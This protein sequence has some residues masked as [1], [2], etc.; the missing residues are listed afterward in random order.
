MT[1]HDHTAFS[2]A[3][4]ERVRDEDPDLDHLIRVSTR[5]GTRLRRRRTVGISVAAV[6]AGVA[7]V[8]IVGSTLGGAGGTS[9]SEPGVASEPTVTA[10]TPADPVTPPPT[11][12]KGQDLPVHVDP[13][14]TGWEIGMAADEKFPAS[15][16]D[17]FLSVNVRPLSEYDAWGGGDP[18]RPGNEVIHVGDNYFVTLQGMDV[19][20]A[21]AAELTDALS[22]DATWDRN[23]ANSAQ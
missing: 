2:S 15:K 10:S 8:G 3:L 17:Y 5:A 12:P 14:L 6:A 23:G 13:A 20:P 9:D 4:D 18:D 19:P 11:L 16:G 7:V 22:Y 1:S 21:V